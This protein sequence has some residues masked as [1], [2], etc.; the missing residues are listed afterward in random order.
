MS[1]RALQVGVLVL[2]F[3]AL[4]ACGPSFGGSCDFPKRGE[5]QA[6]VQGFSANEVK[7]AC[8]A[9]KASDP[10]LEVVFSAT[11]ACPTADLLGSCRSQKSPTQVVTTSY[12]KRPGGLQTSE[13]ARERCQGTFLPAGE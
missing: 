10:S 5:C 7:A 9:T 13:E 1:M 2:G 12:Y 4:V 6:F 3:A 11:D 8:E